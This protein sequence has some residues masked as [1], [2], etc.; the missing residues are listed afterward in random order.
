MFSGE[1]LNV[2]S[3]SGAEAIIPKVIQDW[4][5]VIIAQASVTA[6]KIVILIE[7]LMLRVLIV[8]YCLTRVVAYLVFIDKVFRY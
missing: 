7:Y 1:I 5:E 6:L 8:L 4:R 3:D 2:P